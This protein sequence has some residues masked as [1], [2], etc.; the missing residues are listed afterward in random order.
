MMRKKRGFLLTAVVCLAL[1]LT[2]G[3]AALAAGTTL[4]TQPGVPGRTPSFEEQRIFFDDFEWADTSKGDVTLTAGDDGL[5]PQWAGAN[6]QQLKIVAAKNDGEPSAYGNALRLG[7]LA[8]DNEVAAFT[9]AKL[10]LE[11]G[12]RYIVSLD[13][14]QTEIEYQRILIWDGE[15]GGV[16]GFIGSNDTGFTSYS[17]AESKNGAELRIDSKFDDRNAAN[18]GWDKIQFSF[19]VPETGNYNPFIGFSCRPRADAA[20]PHVLVDNFKIVKSTATYLETY[21][22]FADYGHYGPIL[23]S[24]VQAIETVTGAGE[25]TFAGGGGQ[26]SGV[27]SMMLKT[28]SGAD[29]KA[30]NGADVAFYK[31]ELNLFTPGAKNY[32]SMELKTPY[33]DSGKNE[34]KLTLKVMNGETLVGSVSGSGDGADYAAAGEVE[35]ISNTACTNGGRKVIFAFTASA[36]QPKLI[37]NIKESGELD[38]GNGYVLLDNV[39]FRPELGF[40]EPEYTKSEGT[41]FEEEAYANIV[42]EY[43]KNNPVFTDIDYAPVLS[44][45]AAEGNDY[46]SLVL[47]GKKSMVVL[48]N[49]GDKNLS[50]I[51]TFARIHPDRFQSGSY[52]ISMTVKGSGINALRFL[53]KDADNNDAAFAQSYFNPVNLAPIPD[54]TVPFVQ[55]NHIKN[56]DGSTTVN[57]YLEMPARGYVDIQAGCVQQSDTPVLV[58]DDVCLDLIPVQH[59]LTKASVQNGSFSLDR[60]TAAKGETVTVTATPDAGYRMGSVTV[61]GTPVEGLS[62]EMPDCDAE[63]AV[64]FV[65]TF[66]VT[67]PAQTQGGSVTA[68]RE[69]A[70]AGERV[71]LTVTPDT[72]YE[73]ESIMCNGNEIEGNEFVMPAGDA[74]ITVIFRKLSFT[75]SYTNPTGATI[76][77]ENGYAVN[78][79]YGEEFRFKVVLD[80]GYDKSVLTVKAGEQTLT[81]DENGVYTLLVTANVTVNVTGVAANPSEKTGCGGVGGLG[82]GGFGGLLCLAGIAAIMIEKQKR[83][84]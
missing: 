23:N 43:L 46:E 54:A 12:Y 25:L 13:I 72:G 80:E 5:Y 41:D 73:L 10:C 49:D 30:E 14:K 55:S 19:T 69:R 52:R 16:F 65:Q 71:T 4:E 79:K 77:P 15:S 61:N 2:G 78:V 56:A 76:Q 62:F 63:V 51:Q 44:Y 66:A 67:L 22:N 38:A 3:I 48:M 9:N 60:E 75:V 24:G 59:A 21:D 70:A 26:I 27:N 81:A 50:G 11:A 42:G 82:F 18:E 83:R 1:S 74:E 32:I 17:V 47:N 35:L 20:D 58:I 6:G 34:V 28:V 31:P 37:F 7:A 64:S 84:D 8:G 68:D 29:S 40:A 36:A 53:F 33:A 39:S 57:L 45:L